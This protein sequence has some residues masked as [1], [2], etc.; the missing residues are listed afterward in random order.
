MD[1]DLRLE[2]ML[3][4]QPIE[5]SIVAPYADVSVVVDGALEESPRFYD[6]CALNAYLAE[7]EADAADHG[8]PTEVYVLYHDHEPR[9]CECVQYLQDHKPTYSYNQ[10]VM[11][12]S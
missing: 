5:R 9:E 8:Y 3:N 6:E 11:E 1:P 10:R 2:D 12:E 4:L 7:I